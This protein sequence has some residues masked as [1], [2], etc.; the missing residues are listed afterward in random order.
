MDRDVKLLF[1]ILAIVGA[2][3]IKNHHHDNS[4]ISTNTQSL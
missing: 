4:D 2:I 3:R 1:I